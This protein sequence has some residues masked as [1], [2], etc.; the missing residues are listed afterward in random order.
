MFIGATAGIWFWNV[1]DSALFGAATEKDNC[2]EIMNS[3]K[4]NFY[5]EQN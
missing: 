2:L 4:V 5:A 1:L 3:K